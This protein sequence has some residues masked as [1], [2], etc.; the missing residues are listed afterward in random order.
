MNKYI[1]FLKKLKK[2]EVKNDFEDPEKFRASAIKKF[3]YWFIVEN[4]FPY[5]AIAKESH[6]ILPIRK[7][8]FDWDLL[9]KE[10]L[11]EFNELKKTYIS[12]KYDVVYENLPSGRSMPMWFHVHLLILKRDIIKK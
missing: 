9:T 2:G 5:D 8:E 1:D 7:V 6:M 10:E 4:N 11:E 3:K 12:E